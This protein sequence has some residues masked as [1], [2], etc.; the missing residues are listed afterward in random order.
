VAQSDDCEVAVICGTDARYAGEAS[1]A[2]EAA[3]SAGVTHVLLAGPEK[4]VVDAA[5]KP[6]GYVTAKIDAV[7]TLSELLTR[8]GA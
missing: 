4:A 1:A 2:V 3:K 7:A 5:V 6:D 8:L